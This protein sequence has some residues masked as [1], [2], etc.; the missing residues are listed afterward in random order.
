MAPHEP[1]ATSQL[2]VTPTPSPTTVAD[3]T[4]TGPISHKRPAE[5]TDTAV[6]LESPQGPVG[7][8]DEEDEE[9]GEIDD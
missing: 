8:D 7:D 4:P 3:A 1:E 6:P 2:T 9:M 5:P